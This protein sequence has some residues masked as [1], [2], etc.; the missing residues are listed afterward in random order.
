MQSGALGVGGRREGEAGTGGPGEGRVQHLGQNQG[1]VRTRLLAPSSQ[2]DS[3][4]QLPGPHCR[5]PS[6]PIPGPHPPSHR[7]SS[8]IPRSSCF[9]AASPER[10]GQLPAPKSK[11]AALPDPKAGVWGVGRPPEPLPAHPPGPPPQPSS[12]AL[13]SS[14]R[15]LEKPGASPRGPSQLVP[16][17]VGE[18]GTR[19]WGRAACGGGRG[20]RGGQ[21]SW[22]LLAWA[23]GVWPRRVLGSGPHPAQ[24]PDL[25]PAVE[26]LPRHPRLEDQ[27]IRPPGPRDPGPACLS[28]SEF[29]TDEAPPLPRAQAR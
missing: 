16:G 22:V 5:P 27:R 29:G 25:V 19:G 12:T 10:L 7:P 3:G 4:R 21:W 2:S 24:S 6:P 23:A 8:G 15:A 13:W 17:R 1:L 14:P 26:G 20:T 9:P 28:Q 11:A 18:T